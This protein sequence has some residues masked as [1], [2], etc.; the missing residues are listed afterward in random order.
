MKKLFVSAVLC[1]AFSSAVF[2]QNTV[3]VET[4]DFTY[5]KGDKIAQI[6]IGVGASSGSWGY[7]SLGF[8]VSV[9][10]SLEFGI[11][12]FISIGPYLGFAGY[13]YDYSIYSNSS[14]T[15]LAFGAKSSLHIIPFITE[16][17]DANWTP[18]KLDLY[19]ALYTGLQ[20]RNDHYDF[21]GTNYNNSDLG[22]N[23]GFVPGIRYMPSPKIGFFGELG[24]GPLS[25]F[26]A[27]VAFEF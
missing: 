12:D 6:G 4:S 2:A 5:N 19:V 9:L 20:I 1:I 22:F 11:H 24:Y 7:G 14:L 13:D 26:T 25:F 21:G 16:V 27:G 18:D 8:G 10:G 17:F 15:Y 3:R 23:F